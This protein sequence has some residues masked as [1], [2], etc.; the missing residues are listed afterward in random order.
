MCRTG[1]GTGEEGWGSPG[2]NFL[3]LAVWEEVEE[4]GVSGEAEALWGIGKD[5]WGLRG[6]EK[7]EGRKQGWGRECDA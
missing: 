5:S 7:A 3:M 1:S 2:G 6:W 4:L